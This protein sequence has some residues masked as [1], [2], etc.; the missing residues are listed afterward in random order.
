MSDF[1]L[2]GGMFPVILDKHASLFD[3]RV[4]QFTHCVV[5]HHW[6]A[7]TLCSISLLLEIF[8]T[9]HWVVQLACEICLECVCR[10]EW[11]DTFVT[12]TWNNYAR[13]CHFVHCWL[14]VPSVNNNNNNLKNHSRLYF[15]ITSLPMYF[16]AVMYISPDKC[17]YKISIR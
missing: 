13:F 5:P 12:F 17:L 11:F 2:P 4:I 7:F 16:L 15:E 9:P 10:F 1:T 14:L 3:T 8:V 6:L